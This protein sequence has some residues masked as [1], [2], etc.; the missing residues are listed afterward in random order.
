MMSGQ[1]R[2]I[3]AH[4]KA[5]RWK[6][7]TCPETK[8]LQNKSYASWLTS[9][10]ACLKSRLK[11]ALSFS[12]IL[13]AHRKAC[14]NLANCKQ[15]IDLV[16]NSFR[17]NIWSVTMIISSF[18]YKYT[19]GNLVSK[20][21]SQSQERKLWHHTSICRSSKQKEIPACKLQH[22]TVYCTELL[23]YIL[24]GFRRENCVSKSFEVSEETLLIWSLPTP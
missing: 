12:T 24:S 15:E 6:E 20:I 2:Q 10:K 5:W 13:C 22:C 23:Q 9:G 21:S 16:T 11:L 8:Y 17:S 7:T 4:T 1:S 14:R 19:N 18:S 3:S